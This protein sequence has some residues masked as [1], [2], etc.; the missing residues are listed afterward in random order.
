MV[1]VATLAG[2]TAAFPELHT[3]AVFLAA[4]FLAEGDMVVGGIKRRIGKAG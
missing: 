4:A 3:E 1:L 2:V